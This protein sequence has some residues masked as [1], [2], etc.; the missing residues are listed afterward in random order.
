MDP[1]PHQH[2][3]HRTDRRGQDLAGLRPGPERMPGGYSALYLRLP[4]MLR[5]LMAAKDLGQYPKQLARLAKVEF[6][7][8]DDWGLARLTGENR[9]DLLEV[10]DDRHGARSTVIASQLPVEEWHGLVGDPTLADAILDRLIHNAHR[11]GLSGPSMRKLHS[12]W[13]KQEDS[14]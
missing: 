10:L 2:P 6:L 9:R 11:I 5:D 14:G 13:T 3:D 8:I 12:P 7:L 1:R 4:R